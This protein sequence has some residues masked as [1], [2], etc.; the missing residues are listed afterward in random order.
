MRRAS[1]VDDYVGAFE[2]DRLAFGHH[3]LDFADAAAGEVGAGVG[4]E[5]V[6]LEAASELGEGD[7]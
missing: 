7:L 6:A 2:V 1:A 4:G 3:L 5:G